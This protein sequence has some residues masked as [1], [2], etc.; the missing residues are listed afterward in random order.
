MA[1]HPSITPAPTANLDPAQQ[2]AHAKQEL[3]QQL[4]RL[5]QQL[6]VAEHLLRQKSDDPELI[7]KVRELLAA[8]IERSEAVRSLARQVLE[9]R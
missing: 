7:R 5:T 8:E 2:L 4:D 1:D 3:D 6:N 9:G